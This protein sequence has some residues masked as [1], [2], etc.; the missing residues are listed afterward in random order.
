MTFQL[1]EEQRLIIETVRRIKKEKMVPLVEEL[2]KKAEFPWAVHKILLDNG[3]IG[4]CLPKEYG[5][6]GLDLLTFAMVA[7]ELANFCYSLTFWYNDLSIEPTLIAGTPEQKEKYLRRVAKGEILASI[8]LTEPAAG[9]D[10]AS[11]ST[12][13]VLD[14]D[15]YIINGTKRFI[16]L[17]DDAEIVHVLAR[18]DPSKG[19]KGMS[20]FIVEKGTP[21]FSI[22]KPENKMGVD[23]LHACELTF[24]NCRVPRSNLVGKEGQGFSIAME[25][26]DPGRVIVGSQGVGIA[27]GALDYAVDYA[28]QRVQ[29]GRP[30]AEFQGLQFMMADM[31]TQVEASRQLVRRAGWA[32]D[33]KERDKGKLAAL[34]KYFSTDTC[35]KV[36]TEAVQ[37]LGGYGYTKDYPLERMMREAKFLQIYEGTNQIQRILVARALLS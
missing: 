31:A 12:T 35:M 36:T 15:E 20:F 7:E 14:G 5:G 33:V 26:L 13:A 17:A 9:S 34:A 16:S 23:C 24:E 19:T 4:L 8:A 37:I 25:S 3:L 10:V 1:S 21:G 22:G 32:V 27:Q 29:F 28:K 11:I 18:T 30:I 6:G 2:E